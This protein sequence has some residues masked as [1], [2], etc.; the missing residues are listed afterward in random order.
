MPEQTNSHQSR[1][2]MCMTAH[3]DDEAGAFGGCLRKYGDLGVQTSVICLTSGQAATHRCGAKTD[4]ELGAISRKD[5]TTACE[6]VNVSEG[7]VLDYP[8]GQLYRQDLYRVVCD[9][10]RYVRRF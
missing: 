4:Q 6:M 9:L 3:P 10:T 8:D 2:L 1:R 7:T 5:F